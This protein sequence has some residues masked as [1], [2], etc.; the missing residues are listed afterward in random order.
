MLFVILLDKIFADFW[1][2]LYSRRLPGSS[3]MPLEGSQP[4]K[5]KVFVIISEEKT[6]QR[7]I[8]TKNN[9]YIYN[10]IQL[11]LISFILC[12]MS[13]LSCNIYSAQRS[14]RHQY[15]PGQTGLIHLSYLLSKVDVKK[16]DPCL[17]YTLRV[18]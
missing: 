15:N 9:I 1:H 7:K 3:P 13:S 2:N 10:A 6:Y 18:K 12:L 11:P 16:Q 4:T 5:S 17:I 14:F 8:H